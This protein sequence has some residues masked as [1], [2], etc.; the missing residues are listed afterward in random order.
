MLQYLRL[1]HLKL[2]APFAKVKT[3]ESALGLLGWSDFQLVLAICDAGS[4]A[5]ARRVL[6][7]THST[8]LRRLDA[9][10]NRLCT[11]LFERARAGYTL[12][13]AGAEIVQA[14]RQFAPLAKAAERVASGQDLQPSGDVRVS[15]A[16]VV[17]DH[18]LPPLLRAFNA[19]WPAVRIEFVASRERTRL[20]GCDADVA[21]RIADQVPDWLVGRRLANLQ[22]KVYGLRD[23]QQAEQ[24]TR[25]S[26]TLCAAADLR[27]ERRWIGLQ[28]DARDLK[29]DR[30]L[31][32][33]VDDDRVVLRVDDFSHALV[34]LRAGLG[35]AL[36]P[37]FLEASVPELLPLTPP[38]A[39]L[40]TPIWLVT[41]PELKNTARVRVM[42]QAFGPA[43]TARIDAAQQQQPQ[44]RLSQC[45]ARTAR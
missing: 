40:Q 17:L 18:L 36:L 38:V 4:V 15:V 41:H 5:H 42:M 34:M 1:H 21:I 8:L 10:E 16:S 9:I 19:E 13:L 44:I 7:W 31:A 43:L 22:F 2:T 24:P 20:R 32:T 39:E 11:R 45:P 14:A 26:V 28:R 12:T 29:F 23:G 27:A 25:Q 37:A 35:I 6:G 30:W 33:H 3:N